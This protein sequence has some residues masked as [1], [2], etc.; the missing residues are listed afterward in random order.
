ME[1]DSP[2]L[3]PSTSVTLISKLRDLTNPA[4]SRFFELYAPVV[5]RLSRR[6]GMNHNDAEDTVAIVMR[7]FAGA[8][9]SGFQLDPSVG[10]FRSYFRTLTRRTIAEQRQKSRNA[11]RCIGETDAVQDETPDEYWEEVERQ[12]RWRTCLEQL[13]ALPEVSQRDFN[14]FVDFAIRG[15]PSDQVAARYG[16]SRNRLYEIRDKMLHCLSRLRTQLDAY[17]GEV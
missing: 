5:Y 6:M 16:V 11:A 12:E 13:R 3:F 8:V 4:W 7:N 14:A 9:R 15:Q 10:R 17:L 2:S 1:L